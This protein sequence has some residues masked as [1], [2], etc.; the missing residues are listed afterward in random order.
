MQFRDFDI[1]GFLRDYWQ[2]KPLLIRDPWQAWANPIAPD[3]LA[4]LACEPDVESRLIGQMSDNPR[5][6]WTVEHGPLA[7]ARLGAIDHKP[8]TLLVQAV[9]HF[10]PDVAALVT[11]FRFIPNW[12]IDDVMV[13]YATDGGG[14]GPHFDQY[15]VFLIQGQG[16]RRWQ[17]GAVC[18]AATELLPHG[19]LRL[20]ARFEAIE[21]WVLEPGDILYVPPRVAH[22][23]IAVGKDCM[24]Y[25]IGFRAPSRG[26]L[27]SHWGD[28]LLE[29]LDDDDRYGDADLRAQPNPGEIR[30]PALDRLHAMVAERLLDREGFALW[31]G[32][33]TTAPKY[34][35]A[36]WR[37][38]TPVRA[39]DL[40]HLL[41]DGMAL[42][43]NP[44]SR[45][46]FIRTPGARTPDDGLALFVDGERFA[47]A[48]REMALAE[49]L[50]G[51]DRIAIAPDL[52]GSEA[53]MALLV[54]LYN[55]GSLE[56][57]QGEE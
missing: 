2:K 8:W 25:S 1:D 10:M 34:P 12:R 47:C 51:Q 11:P 29:G 6:P 5:G 19:D 3:E 45:F 20:L 43:R 13:S 46:A 57:D 55:Q 7:E 18:D 50:C 54:A 39:D 38:E 48:G 35:E 41:A 15:D 53:A 16:R 37:P 21:E 31:F 24:T 17:V 9:D 42:C 27:V 33:Y 22:N 4:G 56:L 26:E 49:C 36:D 14:V 52:L 32:Q 23:G 30:A 28:H 40:R 44:A